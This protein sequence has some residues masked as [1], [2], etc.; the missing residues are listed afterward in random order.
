MKSFQIKS[1][2][3][4]TDFSDLSLRALEHAERVAALADARITLL[5]VVEPR[6]GGYGTSGM[7]GIAA[8]LEKKQQKEAAK[9]LRLI[10]L[11]AHT[12]SRV[13]V[14]ASVLIGNTASTIKRAATASRADL[15]V[16]GTHG[17]TG[18]V[19]DVIG[20]NTYRV[21]GH[22]KIPVLSVNK[23]LGR[24][25]YNNLVY[26][27]RDRTQAMDKYDFALTFARLF[28]MRVH[29]IGLLR[30]NEKEYEK[31]MRD[32]CEATKIRF[33]KDGVDAKMLFTKS[34]E[35]PVAIMKYAHTF[36]DSLVIIKQDHDFLLAEMFR[37]TFTKTVLHKVLSPVLTIP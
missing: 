3:V 27:V 36:V 34:E 1:I 33:E 15:I 25:G 16:M 28:E 29:I 11:Q 7:L 17:A 8:Q 10:A 37:G 5:H 12:R 2:L 22:S 21:A 23:G 31:R 14:V 9:N 4:P 30:S 32:S 24:K 18:F 6:S 19:E 35:F 20:S 13:R 26:P